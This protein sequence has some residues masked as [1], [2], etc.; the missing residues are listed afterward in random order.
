MGSVVRNCV[1]IMAI[2]YFMQAAL[3]S[4]V[5]GLV[6]VLE[7]KSLTFAFIGIAMVL[8]IFQYSLG[9]CITAESTQLVPEDMKGTLIG[10]EHSI[11][12][13]AYIITPSLGITIMSSAGVSALYACVGSI[14]L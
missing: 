1:G 10:I 12:S 5:V 13:A 14:F 2:G 3:R 11:F 4:E 8:A 7:T 6:S 9:T